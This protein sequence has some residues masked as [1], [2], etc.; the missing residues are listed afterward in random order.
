MKNTFTINGY[1]LRLDS[2]KTISPLHANTTGLDGGY[3]IFMRSSKVNRR[4]QYNFTITFTGKNGGYQE[5]YSNTVDYVGWGND[6]WDEEF[7]KT[8]NELVKAWEDFHDNVGLFT[9][10]DM[11]EFANYAKCYQSSP[12]VDKAF[13]AYLK[14][15]RIKNR[16]TEK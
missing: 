9:S 16:Y 10:V 7:E 14:G 6:K 2:I 4:S 5:F 3:A 12:K 11:I 13:E 8:Y 1:K 15:E